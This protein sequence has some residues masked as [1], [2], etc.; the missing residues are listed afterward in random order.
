[1]LRG[2]V[3]YPVCIVRAA[4]M[5]SSLAVNYSCIEFIPVRGK[6]CAISIRSRPRHTLLGR[7][8]L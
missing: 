8:A 1:V 5:N 4:L 3:A 7:K 2:G 6:V